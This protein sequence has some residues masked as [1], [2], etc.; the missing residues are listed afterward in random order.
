ADTVLTTD[1]SYAFLID[2]NGMV[3]AFAGAMLVLDDDPTTALGL[4]L[5]T[6]GLL[7]W[8]ESFG[9]NPPVVIATAPDLDGSG[10]ADAFAGRTERS[11]RGRARR[12]RRD[13]GERR[14][15]GR[16][17]PVRLGPVDAGAS[18]G[19]RLR[20][21]LA[22]AARTRPRARARTLARL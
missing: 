17:V 21:R 8:N 9:T 5:S 6:D 14:P 19:R 20:F 13:H 2:N 15:G 10:A 4:F 7:Y 1:G 22:G 12:F 16:Q 3:H 18:A 11:G